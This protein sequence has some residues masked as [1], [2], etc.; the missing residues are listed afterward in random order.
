[1]PR[2]A[3][4]QKKDGSVLTDEHELI[5]RLKQHYD[6]HLNSAAAED[7]DSGRNIFICITD[8]GN[9]PAPTISGVTAAIKQLKNNKATGNYSASTLQKL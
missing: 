4:C 6:E 2:A 5:D 3:V 1:M 9:I 8:D 7:Q